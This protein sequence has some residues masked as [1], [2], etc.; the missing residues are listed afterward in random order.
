MCV[1]DG[2]SQIQSHLSIWTPKHLFSMNDFKTSPASIQ[3]LVFISIVQL[4]KVVPAPIFMS[5]IMWLYTITL[6]KVCGLHSLMKVYVST[7]MQEGNECDECT[8]NNQ[9]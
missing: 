6:I 3:T 9:L 2:L 5:L 7:I 1:E 8:V 4:S